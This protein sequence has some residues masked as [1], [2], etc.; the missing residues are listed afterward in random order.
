[1]KKIIN[2]CLII[3]LGWISAAAQTA[4]PYISIATF[5][6]VVPMGAGGGPGGNSTLQVQAGNA[7]ND[8]IVSN[9]MRITVSVGTN[10]EI[11]GL[12]AG[13]DPR[14]TITSL[15]GGPGGTVQLTN[16]GAGTFGPFDVPTINLTIRGVAVGG[17]QTI[18][19]NIA[20]ILGPNPLLGGAPS[21]SQGNA[22]NTDDNSTTS[23]TVSFVTPVVLDDITAVGNSCNGVLNW[24][25][26]SEQ[27]I[28]RFEI[29]YGAN[30]FSFAL[31][32]T[33]TAKNNPTGSTYQY[34]NAQGTGRGFY[35]LKMIDR[36]GRVEYSKIV[37]VDTKCNGK[38]T[39]TLYPNPLTANNNLNV[40]VSGYEGQIKGDL[41]SM[42]GQ[43]IRSYT[44]KNGSN[45]LPVDKIAQGT[46][47]LKVTDAS[48]DT[49]SFRVIVT[50]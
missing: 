48:G 46:Y 25:T 6:A 19:G 45:V 4:N 5:P 43:L 49:E 28:D 36:D 40:I 34:V 44:L 1:M 37:T 3:M 8:N 2:V 24:K 16:T 15:I 27:N 13:S 10:A 42:A 26:V 41:V 7:G 31:V 20:Y 30:V 14:W 22:S 21:S 17:P 18:T 50:K 9:S 29:E 12:G 23:L 35:R 33:V 32:G 47:V 39:V 11:L 38:K